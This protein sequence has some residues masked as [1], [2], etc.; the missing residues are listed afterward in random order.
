MDDWIITFNGIFFIT[1]LG[2]L[3]GACYKSK[4]SEIKLCSRQGFLFIKRDIQGE[5]EEVKLELEHG[6]NNV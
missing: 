2:V 1:I 3:V 4:C 6:E 5:N